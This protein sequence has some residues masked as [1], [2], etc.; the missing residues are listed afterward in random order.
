MHSFGSGSS[1]VK[2]ENINFKNKYD[3]IQLFLNYKI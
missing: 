1:G 3:I 2:S